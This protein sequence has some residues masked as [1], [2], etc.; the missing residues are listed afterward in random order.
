MAH[1]N[2]DQRLSGFVHLGPDRVGSLLSEGVGP[3]FHIAACVLVL[4]L[5]VL[6]F[7][8]TK[9]AV[10]KV[11]EFGRRLH[12]AASDSERESLLA[13]LAE[14]SSLQLLLQERQER[15]RFFAI[16]TRNLTKKAQAELALEQVRQH[17]QLLLVRERRLLIC[18]GVILVA[19][20]IGGALLA[21]QLHADR[22]TSWAD[23]IKVTAKISGVD[24]AIE[25]SSVPVGTP[26]YCTLTD[27]PGN[28]AVVRWESRL[29][30]TIQDWEGAHAVYLSK[31]I[32]LDELCVLIE[33]AGARARVTIPIRVVP[34]WRDETD[35]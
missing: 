2:R 3:T 20:V 33:R 6:D 7:G 16:D 18:A 8:C 5:L 9:A 4:A 27:M 21:E 35:E 22:D 13:K 10:D 17:S 32:T 31:A 25:F 28:A 11:H 12:A 15:S 34:P 30:D 23:K 1:L 29:A 26:I 24:Q 14:S 19:I